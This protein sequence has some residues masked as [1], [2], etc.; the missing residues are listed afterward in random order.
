[1]HDFIFL[2]DHLICR[3]LLDPCV[4]LI[5]PALETRWI[6]LFFRFLLMSMKTMSWKLMTVG[7][8]KQ[9]AAGQLAIG[10]QL[11]VN[12]MGLVKELLSQVLKLLLAA[13]DQIAD[14][15]DKG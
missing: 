8:L 14:V 3:I 10:S 4:S 9:M 1:M 2:H 6:S 13:P 5:L 15:C 7:G 11:S 12:Q